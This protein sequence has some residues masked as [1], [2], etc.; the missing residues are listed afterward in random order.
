MSSEKR[1]GEIK[2]RYEVYNKMLRRVIFRAAKETSCREWLGR[3]TNDAGL[4]IKK[5][6]RDGR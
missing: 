4:E 6:R 3:L 1:S 2:M 5:I